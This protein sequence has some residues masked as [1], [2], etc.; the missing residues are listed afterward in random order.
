MAESEGKQALSA[1]KAAGHKLI[2]LVVTYLLPIATFFVGLFSGYQTW[3]GINAVGSAMNQLGSD[4][5]KTAAYRLVS[6]GLF[7]GVFG[8]VGYGFW[9]LDGHMILKGVGRGL[10]GYF[11]GVALSYLLFV[12]VGGSSPDG[13]IDNL[14]ADIQG[15]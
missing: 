14:I 12:F 6:A 11:Y 5:G 15:L 3:G 10:G 8:A 9:Q 1:T 13:L 4:V 7:G 2:D